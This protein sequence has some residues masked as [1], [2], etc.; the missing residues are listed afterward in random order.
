VIVTSQPADEI[1]EVLK[2]FSDLAVVVLIANVVLIGLLYLAFGRA[3]NPLTGLAEGLRELEQGRF[4]HRL[5]RPRVRELAD[6]VDRFNALAGTLEAARTDN[7]RLNRRLITVQDDER[8]Q[9]A[10]ELHDELGACLFGL[11]A[12]VLSVQRLAESLPPGTA[13]HMRQRAATLAEVSERIQTANRRV[14]RRLRPMAIGH[15]ALADVIRDLVAEFERND[16]D[17]TFKLDIGPLRHAYS[18]C[19]DLTVYRCVQEGLTNAVRHAEADTVAIRLEELAP[20][21]L[22]LNG[23]STPVALRISVSDDGCGFA[24]G[25]SRGLGLTG[26]E[27]RIRALGG[28]FVISD[29]LAG[30][31]CLKI[32]IPVE[33]AEWSASVPA[34]T[35]NGI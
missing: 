20:P 24:P 16:P 15:A 32:T 8:R 5:P 7:T 3:L 11:R 14:L 1:A 34:D 21:V 27:E 9:I 25:A 17:R 6:I 35:G 29:G 19:I 30:G 2:D 13:D 28:V 26:M 33:D 18:D 22:K 23:W 4:R 31:T 10:T 12:N